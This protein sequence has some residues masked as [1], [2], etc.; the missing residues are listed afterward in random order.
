MKRE[1]LI[2]GD[3]SVTIHLPDWNEQYHSKH[4]AVA[5]AI[6]V[7]IETGLHNWLTENEANEVAIL[8]I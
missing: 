3:G 4:G 1:F 8:E 2:T 5:E 6:H 7:F